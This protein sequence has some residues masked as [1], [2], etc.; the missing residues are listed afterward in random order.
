LPPSKAKVRLGEET[1]GQKKNVEKEKTKKK[2]K[3]IK[4]TAPDGISG[5]PPRSGETAAPEETRAA[6]RK[7]GWG[8]NKQEAQQSPLNG[9]K[10]PK[11]QKKKAEP[12][13]K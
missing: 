6:S 12:Q 5:Q 11:L 10:T 7:K 9:H 3:Q 1:V 2:K 13:K 4:K 8:K